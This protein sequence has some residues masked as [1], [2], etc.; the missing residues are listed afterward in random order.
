MYVVEFPTNVDD[1]TKSCSMEQDCKFKVLT[2]SVPIETLVTSYKNPLCTSS[3]C[4]FGTLSEL[5]LKSCSVIPTWCI[6][7]YVT[8]SD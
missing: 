7:L 2:L 6:K 3:F 5:E 1:N 4:D 8:Q